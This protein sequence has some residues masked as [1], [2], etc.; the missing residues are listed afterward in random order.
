L[1]NKRES[2]EP[3]IEGAAVEKVKS[4]GYFCTVVSSME[5]GKEAKLRE[6]LIV[7][8]HTAF[9]G[10]QETKTVLRLVGVVA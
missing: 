7:S 6:R 10:Q 3:A 5:K 2:S 4:Y 8:I 9:V 1:H